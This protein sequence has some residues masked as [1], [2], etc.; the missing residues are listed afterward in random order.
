MTTSR[1]GAGRPLTGAQIVHFAIGPWHDLWRN[2]QHIFSRLAREN[3]VVYVEPKVPHLRDVRRGR[4]TPEAWRRP[5]LEHLAEVADGLWVYR[6]PVWAPRTEKA[7]LRELLRGLRGLAL[8]QA[9]ARLGVRRP[10]SWVHQPRDAELV[11]RFGERLVIFQVVDEYSAYRHQTA[12]EQQAVQAEEQRLLPRADLVIVTS[13]ALL[14]SKRRLNPQTVLVPN[15][16]DYAAYERLRAA[17]Q[18]APD[19]IRRLP[20]PI[21]GY[22]GHTSLRLDLRLLDQVAEHRPDWSLA[23]VGSVW[24]KGCEADLARLR[25]RPNV[26]FLGQKPADQVPAYVS[27][28]DVGL[29]PYRPGEEARNISPLKLYEYLAAGKPVVTIDMPALEGFRHAVYIADT[30]EAFLS[31]LDRAI[32]E[33]GPAQAGERRRLAA[34]NT[35]DQRV[36]LISRLVQARLEAL[37]AAGQG[38][39]WFRPKSP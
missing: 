33:D 11:G 4:V 3:L 32:A 36:D 7:G 16:V 38:S 2:R 30:A 20:R 6:H 23:L 24:D 12:K 37:A 28:F 5:R 27:A 21:V 26:H 14:E 31:M 34:E 9:L 29:I 13:P 15:A 17:G 25:A 1:N 22:V 18:A 35:W 19:D 10:I 39:A 8:R